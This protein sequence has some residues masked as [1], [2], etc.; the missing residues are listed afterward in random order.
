MTKPR[1]S[2]AAAAVVAAVLLA[3]CGTPTYTP[4]RFVYESPGPEVVMVPGWVCNKPPLFPGAHRPH[5]REVGPCSPVHLRR[6]DHVVGSAE[7][8]ADAEPT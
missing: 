4:V 7:V 2:V 3:G 5:G 1:R 8:L 6:N